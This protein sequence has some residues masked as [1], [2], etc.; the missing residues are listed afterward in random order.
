MGDRP[1]TSVLTWKPAMR[2]NK[3]AMRLAPYPR[4]MDASVLT[5]GPER[6]TPSSRDTGPGSGGA[7]TLRGW[8]R[9]SQ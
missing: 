7:G 8:G 9:S 3:T 4:N 1:D 5:D 6:W 2:P